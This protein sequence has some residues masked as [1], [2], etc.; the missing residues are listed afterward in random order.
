VGGARCCGRDEAITRPPWERPYGARRSAVVRHRRPCCVS[1]LVARPKKPTRDAGTHLQHLRAVCPRAGHDRSNRNWVGRAPAQ[2]PADRG[3]C[4]PPRRALRRR[5]AYGVA[6]AGSRHPAGAG[7][8]FGGRPVNRRRATAP[9]YRR[10]SG[11]SATVKAVPPT[12][13]RE[14]IGAAAT[15]GPR[16]SRVPKSPQ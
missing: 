10:S 9:F 13:S 6:R 4:R 15:S 3:W 16:P 1:F 7:T 5:V 2:G 11:A 8:R 14:R 12:T